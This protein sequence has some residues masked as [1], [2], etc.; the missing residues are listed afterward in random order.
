[1]PGALVGA[2]SCERCGSMQS[3]DVLCESCGTVLTPAAQGG[4]VGTY[5]PLLAG[6][7]RS[8]QYAAIWRR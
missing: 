6:V 2:A 8:K 5:T 3:A 7:A 4:V 1:M